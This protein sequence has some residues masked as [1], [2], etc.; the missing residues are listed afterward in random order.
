M[1]TLHRYDSGNLRVLEPC[2][3]THVEFGW[4]TV[5]TGHPDIK[6]DVNVVPIKLCYG[7]MECNAVRSACSRPMYH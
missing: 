1:D 5:E 7:A 2:G 6:I 3:E 4:D